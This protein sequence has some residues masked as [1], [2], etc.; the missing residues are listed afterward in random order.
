MT[1][2]AWIRTS[3]GWWPGRSAHLRR[4]GGCEAPARSAPAGPA[5]WGFREGSPRCG[6]IWERGRRDGVQAASRRRP[7]LSSSGPTSWVSGTRAGSALPSG[8][9]VEEPGSTGTPPDRS[10]GGSHRLPF[11][12]F[13]NFG[14]RDLLPSL[15]RICFISPKFRKGVFKSLNVCLFIIY[16]F[17]AFKWMRSHGANPV[18]HLGLASPD[19]SHG[20]QNLGLSYL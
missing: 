6:P 19:I 18:T 5:G 3:F 20:K 8:F 13:D 7:L 12:V 15:G 17:L 14:S 1:L 11:L 4:L 16:L 2:P 10:A 9:S